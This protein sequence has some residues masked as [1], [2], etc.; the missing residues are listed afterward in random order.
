ML[1][2]KVDHG[3]GDASA[4]VSDQIDSEVVFR[5]MFEVGQVCQVVADVSEG[6]EYRGNVH[7]L[8]VF[9]DDSVIEQC[10][11]QKIRNSSDDISREVVEIDH[12]H[13]VYHLGK[14]ACGGQKPAS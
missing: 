11:S 13:R 3:D 6:N 1:Q 9:I 4:V 5:E 2:N 12:R 8:Q 14:N 10:A 7:E